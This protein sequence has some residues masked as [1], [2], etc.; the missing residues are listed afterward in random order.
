MDIYLVAQIA[1]ICG[2]A[3]MIPTSHDFDPNT[4][5]LY[6]LELLPQLGE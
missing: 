2:L 4:E 6:A 1:A 5:L 3:P